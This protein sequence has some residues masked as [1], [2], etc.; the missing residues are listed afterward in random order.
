M[1]DCAEMLED[2]FRDWAAADLLEIR[3][4]CIPSGSMVPPISADGS[5]SRTFH[6]STCSGSR[7]KDS[8]KVRLGELLRIVCK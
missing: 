3:G 1:Y 5:G 2:R 4:T 8:R 7:G 6:W